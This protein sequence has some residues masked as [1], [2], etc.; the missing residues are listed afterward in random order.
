MSTQ[1]IQLPHVTM[2]IKRITDFTV[3]HQSGL[4]NIPHLC[5]KA[6]HHN[7]YAWFGLNLITFQSR[8]WTAEETATL[9]T[10]FNEAMN[11]ICDI[12]EIV[13]DM[14]RLIDSI[15][16]IVIGRKRPTIF[17]GEGNDLLQ[18][19]LANNIQLDVYRETINPDSLTY[20]GFQGAVLIDGEWRDFLM[21]HRGVIISNYIDEDTAEELA[22]NSINENFKEFLFLDSDSI[23]VDRV[24]ER[25]R[26]R[27][28]RATA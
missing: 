11:N 25:T 12:K 18:M 15:Q 20:G 3:N 9:V 4:D 22:R 21:Y 24:V 19:H 13:T 17:G 7:G 14:D 6:Q 16:D 28:L 5:V 8:Q 10:R 2:V 26:N 23:E 27:Q 1:I